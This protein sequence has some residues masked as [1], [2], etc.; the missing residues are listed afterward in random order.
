MQIDYRE[1]ESGKVVVLDGRLDT[2]TA[3]IVEAALV[4]QIEAGVHS[5]VLNFEHLAY[6]SSAGLR[7]L[8]V[9][10]KRLK[11]KGGSMRIAA[12]ND[13]VQEVFD[14]SGFGG[15]FKTFPSEQAA[16]ESLG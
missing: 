8:L 6:V 2:V 16:V 11:T 15:L 7:V 14:I 10:A 1:L 3:P 9:V 12:L 13:V 4:E 5:I